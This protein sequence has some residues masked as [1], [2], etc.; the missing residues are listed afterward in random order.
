M[1]DLTGEQVTALD[2]G[3]WFA[4]R[5]ATE[6]IPTLR[7]VLAWASGRVYLNLDVRNYPALGCYDTA[8]TAAE[9]ASV[10]DRAGAADQ[11]IV[12]CLDHQLAREVHERY[13]R[14]GVGIT[15]HG[16]PADIVAM[17]R[18]AGATLISGDAAFATP[19][20]AAELHR[21]GIGLMTS[22]ELRLPGMPDDGAVLASSTARLQAAGV[23]IVVTDDPAA[24]ASALG[25]G[26]HASLPFPMAF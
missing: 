26:G 13:P 6:R 20:L 22:A 14:V 24:T 21:A 16:R 3:S 8:A 17:A 1:L 11:V 2:A 19:A 9:L 4:P 7:Q 15:V 23:D 5:F 25:P 12:Q 10:I 18:A